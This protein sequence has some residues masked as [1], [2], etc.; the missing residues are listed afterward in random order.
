MRWD[1]VTSNLQPVLNPIGSKTVNE[2]QTLTFTVTGSDPD[3]DQTLSYSAS[4]LPTGATFDPA[5]QTFT[6]TPAPGSA[7][8]YPVT[9]TVTDSGTPPLSASET[10]SITVNVPPTIEASLAIAPPL[11]NLAITKDIFT[12]LIGL[13][14]G[15]HTDEIDADTVRLSLPECPE[16]GEA[17]VTSTTFITEYTF[18]FK[19]SF[20]RQAPLGEVSLKIRGLL[21]DGTP[22][23]GSATAQTWKPVSL[24]SASLT[25]ALGRPATEFG[26][27][28]P[29]TL[30]CSYVVDERAGGGLRASL[31]IKAFGRTFK[32]S[33]LPV[34]PGAGRMGTALLVPGVAP[35]GPQDLKVTLRLQKNG[36]LCDSDVQ[37]LPVKVLEGPGTGW[38]P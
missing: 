30:S 31:L 1:P 38:Q 3:S 25:N 5:T 9:F 4:N 27:N 35:L 34:R 24:T 11:L 14:E 17:P 22:F 28:E 16:C 21:H 6:W 26:R 10:V 2:G 7:G 20:L 36:R 8:N 37:T 23:E 32:T 15:H 33:W 29:V 12:C 13:P 19:R 18:Q